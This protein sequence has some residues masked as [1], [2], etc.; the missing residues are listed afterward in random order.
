S[1]SVPSSDLDFNEPT[2]FLE[3]ETSASTNSIPLKSHKKHKNNL[4]KSNKS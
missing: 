2:S 1:L 3:A 4:N